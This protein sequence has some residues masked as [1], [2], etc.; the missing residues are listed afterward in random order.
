MASYP[1]YSSSTSRL[2]R[3][4]YFGSAFGLGHVLVEAISTSSTDQTG[5]F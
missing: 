5:D 3:S 2:G 1:L 4:I